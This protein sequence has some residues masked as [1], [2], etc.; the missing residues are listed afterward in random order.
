M[1]IKTIITIILAIVS[2]TVNAKFGKRPDVAPIIHNEIRYVA[3]NP[4]FGDA[5]IEAWD[6]SNN[7]R[8][9]KNAKPLDDEASIIELRVVDEKLI[10]LAFNDKSYSLELKTGKVIQN[11]AIKRIYYFSFSL[12][13]IIAVLIIIIK[14][15]ANEGVSL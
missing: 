3:T 8:I 7:K 12:L 2:V 1:K 9:W 4:P 5:Y 14:L 15:K 13:I 10:A 11:K 6:N